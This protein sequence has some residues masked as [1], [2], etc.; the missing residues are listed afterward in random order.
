MVKV[1]RIHVTVKKRAPIIAIT[2]SDNACAKIRTK[3]KILKNSITHT[4]HL[5]LSPHYVS[6]W[7][8]ISRLFGRLGGKTHVQLH[9]N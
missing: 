4:P 8:Y 1:A 5:V 9:E 6:F 7:K 3:V 2:L